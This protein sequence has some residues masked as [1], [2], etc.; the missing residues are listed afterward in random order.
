MGF[1][2][3]RPRGPRFDWIRERRI[4]VRLREAS[5]ALGKVEA[6]F[7]LGNS[8]LAPFMTSREAGN[9]LLPAAG[10]WDGAP[11]TEW[12]GFGAWAKTRAN[13]TPIGASKI[14]GWMR[15]AHGATRT[16]GVVLMRG[17]VRLQFPRSS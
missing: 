12:G 5:A 8:I 9:G 11:T 2:H 16:V 13:F 1:P 4:A 10:G 17:M 6:L 15:I 7:Q 14:S 3:D